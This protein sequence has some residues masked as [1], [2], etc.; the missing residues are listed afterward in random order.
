[1]QTNPAEQ[2]KSLSNKNP[3]K[4]KISL[5]YLLLLFLRSDLRFESEMKIK[6]IVPGILSKNRANTLSPA[7]CR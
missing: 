7:R 3:K 2:K 1:M 4:A 5:F 6:F